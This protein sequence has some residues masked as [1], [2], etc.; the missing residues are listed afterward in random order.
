VKVKL[1]IPPPAG[2]WPAGITPPSTPAPTVVVPIVMHDRFVPHVGVEWRAVARER[3]QLFARAGYEYD[4]TPIGPQTGVTNY[5]DRDRHALSLGLG[6]RL[7]DLL[8]ELPRDLRLDGHV[9][10][11]VLPEAATLKASAADF[12]GDYTAGGHILNLGATLTMGF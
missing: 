6:L 8:P 1:D 11:S 12:V 2:G 4:K 7:V 9:Q 5:I 10:W 3:W